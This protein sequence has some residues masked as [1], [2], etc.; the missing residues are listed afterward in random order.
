M[1]HLPKALGKS[2][3]LFCSWET[4][5][6]IP[7]PFHFPQPH[8]V[9]RGPLSQSWEPVLLEI[10]VL[11]REL[12]GRRKRGAAGGLSNDWMKGAG[13]LDWPLEARS[14]SFMYLGNSTDSKALSHPMSPWSLLL[15][16]M[17]AGVWG[18]PFYTWGGNWPRCLAL[19]RFIQPTPVSKIWE[20]LVEH[21]GGSEFLSCAASQLNNKGYQSASTFDIPPTPHPTVE[22]GREWDIG[23]WLTPKV[24]RQS[25]SKMHALS[26]YYTASCIRAAFQA[27]VSVQGIIRKYHYSV[28]CFP[29]FLFIWVY[30][31]KSKRI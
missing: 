31:S 5:V 26:I 9:G 27:W 4:S 20:S 3:C 13:Y 7:I 23:K 17:V 18:A 15:L 2:G 21:A 8:W 6:L 11:S 22:F 10:D 12:L 19:N 30:I 14:I 1:H 16:Q 24:T 29:C 25:D 28:S